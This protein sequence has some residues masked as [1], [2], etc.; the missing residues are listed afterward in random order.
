VII[1]VMSVARRDFNYVIG[2]VCIC[3]GAAFLQEFAPF[4]PGASSVDTETESIASQ[5]DGVPFVVEGSEIP[6]ILDLENEFSRLPVPL[7][8]DRV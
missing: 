7:V 1:D 2:S 8:L 6:A 5:I 4:S 3:K